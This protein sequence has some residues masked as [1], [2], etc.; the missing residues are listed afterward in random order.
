MDANEELSDSS[1]A[2]LSEDLLESS[3]V[4]IE[5]SPLTSRF[6]R[7]TLG[8]VDFAPKYGI[9]VALDVHAPLIKSALITQ[10]VPHK[11]MYHNQTGLTEAM[12]PI[13]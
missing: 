1:G 9:R 8:L 6:D 13:Q 11:F 7:Y 3:V 4:C 12:H 2:V 5:D 10:R